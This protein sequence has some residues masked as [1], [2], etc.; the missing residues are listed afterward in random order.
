MFNN[1]N[2]HLGIYGQLEGH[3]RH[4]DNHEHIIRQLL[5]RYWAE[6]T[7]QCKNREGDIVNQSLTNLSMYLL[8]DNENRKQTN[9]LFLSCLFK[10]HI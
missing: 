6:M 9:T 3:K 4:K 2:G 10:Y 8:R 7:K 1:Y 5:L